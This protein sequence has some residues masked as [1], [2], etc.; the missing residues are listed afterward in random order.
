MRRIP[1]WT[2]LDAAARQRWRASARERARALDTELNAFV[3][4]E[5]AKV[6]LGRTLDAMPYAAKDMLRTP[7]HQPNGGLAE[8]GELGIAPRHA[9][10]IT[11]LKPG[12]VRV[13]TSDN[14]V[15]SLPSGNFRIAAIAPTPA[16][17]A[18]CI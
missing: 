10:L 15:H 17:T 13:L 7:S 18:S 14:P 11:R 3:E 1:D 6:R 9:P 16:G 5:A 2:S 4:I 8:A 12:Q